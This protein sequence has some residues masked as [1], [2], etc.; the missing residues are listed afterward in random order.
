MRIK[1]ISTSIFHVHFLSR[2]EL[3]LSFLRFQ[4]FYESPEFKGKFFSLKK[5]KKWYVSNSPK[6]KKTGKFT[7]V[8]D[9]SGFNIPS[10]ILI[11]FFEGKFD[12][13]S[14]REKRL[15]KFFEN[16]KEK[17][18]YIIG[19]YGKKIPSGTLN[20]E[21][22]HGLF[23]TNQE[24]KIKMLDLVNGLNSETRE[25]I[26]SALSSMGGYHPDVFDDEIQAYMVDGLKKLLKRAKIKISDLSFR[27]EFIDFFN[28]SLEDK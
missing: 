17:S 23:Y 14:S 20:H 26:V 12:P 18:F 6:G 21:I 2:E 8:T 7:Y 19:T 16:V 5:F 3:S 27:K 22:A 4:E 11:P 1:E 24:Y 13:L 15:L 10:H 9:W 25:K 28:G